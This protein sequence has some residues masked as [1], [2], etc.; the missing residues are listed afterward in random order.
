MA[1]R[2]NGSQT[3]YFWINDDDDSGEVGNDDV[4]LG[5]NQPGADANN[6]GPGRV[7][8]LRDLVD[9]FPLHIDLGGVLSKFDD[10][11]QVDIR[12][13]GSALRYIE[14]P[15]GYAGFSAS[16]ARIYLTDLTKAQELVDVTLG[17]VVRFA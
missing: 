2:N 10:P 9:F 14:F 4:P 5:A 1:A 8:G 17:P 16:Q 3:F 15:T 7:D 13:S 11:G 12:L 6:G